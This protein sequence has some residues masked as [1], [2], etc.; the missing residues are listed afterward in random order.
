MNEEVKKTKPKLKRCDIYFNK[1]MYDQ[2]ENFFQIFGDN[3]KS[4]IISKAFDALERE[5]NNKGTKN[6]A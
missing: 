5:I 3:R 6:N 1:Q 4:L 2:L